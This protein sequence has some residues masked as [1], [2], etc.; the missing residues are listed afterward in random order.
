MRMR[1][2]GWQGDCGK[3]ARVARAPPCQLAGEADKAWTVRGVRDRLGE[4][5]RNIP[6]SLVTYQ[7]RLRGDFHTS[8][9]STAWLAGPPLPEPA[10]PQGIGHADGRRRPALLAIW[11][12]RIFKKNSP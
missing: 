6:S 5:G 1:A 11:A 7:G 3:A 8:L 2:R 4:A 10:P 9:G 12:D